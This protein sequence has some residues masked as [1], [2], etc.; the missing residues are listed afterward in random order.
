MTRKVKPSILPQILEDEPLIFKIAQATNK[1]FRTVE[2]WARDNSPMLA[3]PAVLIILKK[4]FKLS[5]DQILE[6][7]KDCAENCAAV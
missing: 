4:H 1:K 7:V 6:E 2:Q 3:S 5:E